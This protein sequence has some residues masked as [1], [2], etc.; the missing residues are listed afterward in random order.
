MEPSGPFQNINIKIAYM[1]VEC[2]SLFSFTPKPEIS[3]LCSKQ[4][5]YKKYRRCYQTTGSLSS[6]KKFRGSFS[7]Y[8]A[9]LFHVRRKNLRRNKFCL[10]D[11][12]FFHSQFHSMRTFE[13][14]KHTLKTSPPLR[15]Q[16]VSMYEMKQLSSRKISVKKHRKNIRSSIKR[17]NFV[18]LRRVSVLT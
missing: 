2:F 14:K 9:G 3:E 12:N 5:N 4:V 8:K 15:F 18:Q 11:S 1:I 16:K 7:A 17:S 6:E 13:T 10:F